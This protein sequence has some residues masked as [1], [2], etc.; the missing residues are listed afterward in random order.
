V[1]SLAPA[2]ITT[3]QPTVAEI[4]TLEFR[5]TLAY[6][7]MRQWYGMKSPLQL[8]FHPYF[9]PEFASFPVTFKLYQE[10]TGGAV[11]TNSVP[12]SSLD[13]KANMI[14]Q[15]AQQQMDMQGR[16]PWG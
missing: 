11:C 4:D 10:C 12:K 16:I 9:R 3:D 13:M 5:A 6:E 14:I 2:V 15:S 7:H 1:V 8:S